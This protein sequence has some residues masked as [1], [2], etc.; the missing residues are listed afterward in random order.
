MKFHVAYISKVFV[1]F[2]AGVLFMVAITT[3]FAA[4]D[5]VV[6]NFTSM[7]LGNVTATPGTGDLIATGTGTFGGSVNGQNFIANGYVK[8]AKLVPSSTSISVV[9]SLDVTDDVTANSIGSFYTVTA[10]CASGS[11]PVYSVNSDYNILKLLCADGDYVMACLDSPLGLYYSQS[12]ADGEDCNVISDS[13]S[14]YAQAIC[15]SPDGGSETGTTNT[16]STTALSSVL[17]AIKTSD[18]SSLGVSDVF[19]STIDNYFIDEGINLTEIWE[20]IQQTEAGLAEMENLMESLPTDQN[21]QLDLETYLTDNGYA[22]TSDLANYVTTSSLTSTLRSYATT[23]S[24]N[25]LRTQVSAL[26]K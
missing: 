13:D 4:V 16:G 2:V 17:A 10:A 12:W 3:T 18:S 24:L 7:K 1:G 15:F 21:G 22:N 19:S 14:M 11:C 8:T 23:S 5:S 6:P 26:A 9:G 25:S 20:T